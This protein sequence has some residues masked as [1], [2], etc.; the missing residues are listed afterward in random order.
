[1]ETS[2]KASSEGSQAYVCEHVFQAVQLWLGLSIVV[3][4]ASIDC[5]Q[6]I[7]GIDISKDLRLSLE[8]SHKHVL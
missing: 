6:E 1:M 8:N 7:L 2:L 3:M 5:S 4:T